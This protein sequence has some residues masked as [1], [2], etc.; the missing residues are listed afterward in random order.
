MLAS[1]F[2]VP[3]R[4]ARALSKGHGRSALT[5]VGLRRQLLSLLWRGLQA[6]NFQRDFRHSLPSVV[7]ALAIH[8]W[9]PER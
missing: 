6:Q 3:N 1:A 8:R 4:S 7:S 9:R 2:E 5:F